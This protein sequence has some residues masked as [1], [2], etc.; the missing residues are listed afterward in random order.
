MLQGIDV[1]A[2]DAMSSTTWRDLARQLPAFI[3]RLGQ[4][5][6]YI[7]EDRVPAQLQVAIGEPAAGLLTMAKQSAASAIVLGAQGRSSAL[8]QNRRAV[9]SIAERVCACSPVP[10]LLAA[11]TDQPAELGARYLFLSTPTS[12]TW[13]CSR[14]GALAHG[15]ASVGICAACGDPAGSWISLSPRE[16]L[17]ATLS[18]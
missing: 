11:G 17:R 16:T 8:R 13:S 1:S 4:L 10:V 3:G 18:A 15:G 5:C 9:G 12:G 2:E 7:V 14:C 6:S